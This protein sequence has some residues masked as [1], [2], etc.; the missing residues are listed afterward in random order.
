MKIKDAFLRYAKGETE[1]VDEIYA[2]AHSDLVSALEIE[3][4]KN[5]KNSK[6][7]LFIN[8]DLVELE[9]DYENY[10][11]DEESYLVPPAS[12]FDLNRFAEW[13]QGGEDPKD[14]CFLPED[15]CQLTKEQASGIIY[16]L[17]EALFLL[18]DKWEFCKKCGRVY[19][20]EN[21]GRLYDE[22]DKVD[23]V[24]PD[25]WLGHYCDDCKPYLPA[26]EA[27]SLDNLTEEQKTALC[28][29]YTEYFLSIGSKYDYNEL[30]AMSQAD[31]LKEL[32]Q[33]DIRIDNEENRITLYIVLDDD[34]ISYTM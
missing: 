13:L 5:G 24:L 6:S 33:A 2:R 34:Y 12:E 9:N 26:A 18:P 25:E 7:Y 27:V 30:K 28:A 19:D 20:S 8:R 14:F 4:E 32:K 29:A 31:I 3:E 23:Y 11:G 17:Q 10:N 16:Y 21:E 1:T 15:R 22:D